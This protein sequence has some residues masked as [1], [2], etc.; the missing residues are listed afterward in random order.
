MDTP[1]IRHVGAETAASS[2]PRRTRRR[3]IPDV[4]VSIEAPT[5]AGK[6][7]VVAAIDV[8]ADGLGLVLPEE[9]PPGTEVFL[10]FKLDD[11]AVFGR[12]PAV[13]LHQEG[14]VGGA[15]FREWTPGERLALLEHLVRFYE[16][17]APPSAGGA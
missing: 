11:D 2:R 14:Q 15:S 16:S 5:I 13:I 1:E 7:W 17:E 10:S 12:V 8:N 6:P 3:P 9:L 4:L